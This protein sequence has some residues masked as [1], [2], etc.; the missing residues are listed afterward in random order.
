M[1]QTLTFYV[2][3]KPGEPQRLF[4]ND[5]SEYPLS[6]GAMLGTFEAV[7]EWQPF[8]QDPTAVL[9]EHY[10]QEI[11]RERVDHQCRVLALSEQINRLLCLS[12]DAPDAPE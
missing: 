9:V 12:H 3:Q 1:K 10:Q 4:T 6:F 8:T 7:V 5:M 11:E 2:H